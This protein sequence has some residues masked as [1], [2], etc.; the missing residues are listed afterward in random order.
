MDETFDFSVN[1]YTAGWC[2]LLRSFLHPCAWD[3]RLYSIGVPEWR[4]LLEA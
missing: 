4:Y 2:E 3:S 1:F